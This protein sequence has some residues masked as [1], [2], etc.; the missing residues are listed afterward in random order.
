MRENRLCGVLLL[1]DCTSAA[2]LTERLH[3]PEPPQ[4]D[5]L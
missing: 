3:T 2:A 1:G 5:W 4:A